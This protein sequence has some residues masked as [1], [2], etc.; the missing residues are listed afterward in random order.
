M[1]TKQYT[2]ARN[3]TD[4]KTGKNYVAGSKVELEESEAKSAVDN[5]DLEAA[6]APAPKA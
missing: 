1:A 6:P 5:G 3:F 4:P 2:V